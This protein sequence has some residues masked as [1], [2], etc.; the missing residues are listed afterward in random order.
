MN[1][2][3]FYVPQEE[4]KE[5]I[6]L[7]AR[8]LRYL[9][10]VLRLEEGD[11][12]EIFDGY[13]GRYLSRLFQEEGKWFLKI[14]ERLQPEPPP[15]LKLILGQ[16]LL[17]GEK[18]S[19]VIQKATELGVWE[20]IPIL[21]LRSVPLLEEEESIV[22]KQKRWQRIAEEASRQSNRA[23]VPQ[24]RNPLRL[25]EFL[26]QARGLKIAFWENSRLPLREVLKEIKTI[27]QEV[28]LLIG[29]EGGFSEREAVK[30]EENG[31]HLCSLGP[32]ILRAETAALSALT[33]IQHHFGDMG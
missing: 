27:P 3:R 33:L 6:P 7:K 22:L 20:V 28:T 15:S 9:I 11:E 18:M 29:P 30:I 26:P 19:F 2:P 4:I 14:Y 16:S 23:T 32:R 24:I 13:G 25:E 8:D 17:K 12:V 21:S 31:F 10:R 1:M 5:V